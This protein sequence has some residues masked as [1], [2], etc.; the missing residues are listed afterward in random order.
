VHVINR[1]P[2][3][4]KMKS[5]YEEFT[6]KSIDFMRDFRVDWGEPIIVERP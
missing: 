3:D 2:K 5:P 6:G 4:G 1:I